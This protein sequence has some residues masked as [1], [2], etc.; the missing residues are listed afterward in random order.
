[1]K[2]FIL[3]GLSM[4]V[5]TSSMYAFEHIK[6]LKEFEKKISKGNVIVEFYAPWCVPCKEMKRNLQKV[7][8]KK[9]NIKIYQVNIDKSQEVVNM[10][11]TPQVPAILYIKNGKILQGFVGL[12]QMPELKQD[13][14]TYFKSKNIKVA[15]KG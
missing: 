2:K 5:A 13:I 1:M 6:N 4:M 15:S 7:N 10:Y 14:K 11:G 3:I 8:A 12:K 9:E